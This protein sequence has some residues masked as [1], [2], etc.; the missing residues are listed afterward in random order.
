MMATIFS[1]LSSST[2]W[3]FQ[4]FQGSSRPF[5]PIG[6]RSGPIKF[7]EQQNSSRQGCR[8]GCVLQVYQDKLGHVKGGGNV[9]SA[10]VSHIHNFGA[11]GGGSD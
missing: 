6:Q 7:G 11:T 2:L 9:L 4:G 10:G 3:V 8:S 5:P 1:H